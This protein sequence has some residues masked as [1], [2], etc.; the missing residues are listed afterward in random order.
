TPDIAEADE[1]VFD[2]LSAKSGPIRLTLPGTFSLT[3]FL[4]ESF[5]SGFFNYIQA[6]ITGSASSMGASE[7][8]A[9]PAVRVIK[10]AQVA[11]QQATVLEADD[12]KALG[13]WLN[14]NGFKTRPDLSA[15]VQ[16]YIDAKWK[17][18][19]FK[20]DPSIPG[21][22]LSTKAVRLSFKTSTPFFPYREPKDQQVAGVERQLRVYFVG[23]HR[24]KGEVG[25]GE[26]GG[27]TSYAKPTFEA[28]KLLAG[29]VPAVSGGLTW[30]TAFDDLSNP[31]PAHDELYFSKA[32]PLPIIPTKISWLP[33]IPIELIIILLLAA[34]VGLLRR[35]R[36]PA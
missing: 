18:V 10:T 16:K 21:A 30:L 2:R 14:A 3:S 23:P 26:W 4:L 25:E 36:K 11:G 27:Q 19:A 8:H 1:K 13:L 28:A 6:L 33:I 22:A 24:M 34:L 15:W 9:A 12:A 31:R 20:Y 29:A 35:R 32:A 5:E 17:L 7:Y